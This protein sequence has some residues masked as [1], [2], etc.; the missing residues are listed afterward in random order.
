M[1]ETLDVITG[2]FGIL[3]L[4]DV[5]GIDQ[6]IFLYNEDGNTWIP[7]PLYFWKVVYSNAR[8]EAVAFIGVNNPHES[9]PPVP[10]CNV[11][12]FNVF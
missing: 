8:N 5:D 6:D 3:K 7:A 10:I 12:F 9:E 11:T 2:T 1:K 4:P